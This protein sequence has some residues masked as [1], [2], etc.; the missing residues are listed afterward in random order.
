MK[1]WLRR[2]L[3]GVF[4]LVLLLAWAFFDRQS[5]VGRRREKQAAG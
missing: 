5:D 4:S 3:I 1:V 2:T